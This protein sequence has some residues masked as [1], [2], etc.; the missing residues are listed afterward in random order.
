MKER[1][2]FMTK[3]FSFTILV[4][5]FLIFFG[6][7]SNNTPSAPDTGSG[8]NTLPSFT[9][10]FIASFTPTA[11]F[12][13]T[14]SSTVIADVYEED[15]TPQQAKLITAGVNQLR[16]I[17][18]CN[19]Q[20]WVK[21]NITSSSDIELTT[22]S[23]FPTYIECFADEN[24]TDFVADA[25]DGINPAHLAVNNLQPGTY[26]ANIRAY[27]YEAPGCDIFNYTLSFNIFVH[28]A[29]PY[30]TETFTETET[31]T[32]T[33]T[34][35]STST[36]TATETET[37]Y[38]T[39]TFTNS[40]T[41]SFT[42]TYDA[43]EYDDTTFTAKPIANNETQFRNFWEYNNQDF[44]LFSLPAGSDIFVSVTTTANYV[45]Q[46]ADPNA[47]TVVHPVYG[48][49]VYAKTGNFYFNVGLNEGNYYFI[50]IGYEQNA[51]DYSINFSY[52]T[53]TPTNTF[54]DTATE[55]STHTYTFTPTSTFT[56]THTPT[57][58]PT[59]SWHD[60]MQYGFSNCGY[61]SFD[62]NETDFSLSYLNSGTL[63]VDA[64]YPVTSSAEGSF[65]ASRSMIK[66][67]T[68]KTLIVFPDNGAYIY[69][70]SSEDNFLNVIGN[71]QVGR[72]YYPC[73]ESNG[74]T[75]YVAYT[76]IEG[77]SDVRT[78]VKLYSP[79]YNWTYYG[80]DGGV[81]NQLDTT[82]RRLSMDAYFN[83]YTNDIYVGLIKEGYS[84]IYVYHNNN[85]TGWQ[86]VGSAVT[87][88][89]LP[90]IGDLGIS[91]IDQ[92]N[93]FCAFLITQPDYKLYVK[94]YEAGNWVYAGTNPIAGPAT[95]GALEFSIYAVAPN[96]VYIAYQH[97]DTQK[98]AIKKY[99]G[100][101]WEYVGSPDGVSDGNISKPSIFKISN[102]L[103]CGFID[104]SKL[105][106]VNVMIFD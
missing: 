102:T 53:F 25:G 77:G 14:V 55:T 68:H 65:F 17:D 82:Q 67:L 100:I 89:T 46:I 57:E 32:F 51:T 93:I 34:Q 84:G 85:D 44:I 7:N 69:V 1:I 11:S 61:P 73:I 27:N 101:D 58:T 3:K 15:D 56:I 72:G 87:S 50:L 96:E 99:N 9:P 95:V 81:Y 19:E 33:Y 70:K 60:F 49:L 16:S 13:A 36:E 92:S 31:V 74:T 97:P 8:N 5:S 42:P 4:L 83:S 37:E 105:G 45:F 10:T 59:K 94:K 76:D 104:W 78:S 75:I 21:F 29:T 54:T 48:F 24:K 71:Q 52:L 38:I 66:K 23:Q 47:S 22:N 6:C 28:T 103:Y 62:N 80:G 86:N 64:G 2:P 88:T 26:Y 63:Y 91:V 12:T 106:V 98:V 79:W 35:T 90:A 39:S 40:F 20:D 43:Y 30:L 41:P 18:A